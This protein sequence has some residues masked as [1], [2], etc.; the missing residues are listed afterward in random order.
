MADVEG[1]LRRPDLSEILAQSEIPFW[2]DTVVTIGGARGIGAAT[3]LEF[4]LHGANTVMVHRGELKERK[5]ADVLKQFEGIRAFGGV[6]VGFDRIKGDIT[7]ESV[8]EQ[9]LQA[10]L[11]FGSIAVLDINAAGGAIGGD[12]EAARRLNVEMPQQMVD[13]FLPHME[14]GGVIVYPSSVW[15][16]YWSKDE[17]EGVRML[18]GYQ[19]TAETK[20]EAEEFLIS[21]AGKFAEHGVALRIICG[22]VVSDTDII[23]LFR[24]R[25]K[26]A[27]AALETTT[28]GGEFP[29][30]EDMAQATIESVLDPNLPSVARIYVLGRGPDARGYVADEQ[31]LQGYI[32]RINTAL[33]PFGFEK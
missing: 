11:N 24:L 22:H 33:E 15:S 16:T 27:F 5:Y 26:D 31:A 19:V 2:G 7:E 10:A 8:Q 4:A 29:T 3:A 17:D 13:K 9:V 28:I 14:K 6:G 18:P 23:R 25:N 30:T 12:T 20:H 1:F 21:Q 32:Q